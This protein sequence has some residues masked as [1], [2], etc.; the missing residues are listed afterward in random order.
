[1]SVPRKPPGAVGE[2]TEEHAIGDGPLAAA[3]D[4]GKITKA[5]AIARLKEAKR[6]DSD[7]EEISA[8]EK[9]IALF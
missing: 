3:V 1:M 8:L 9:V 5:L 2:Y 4:D 6:E 7:V